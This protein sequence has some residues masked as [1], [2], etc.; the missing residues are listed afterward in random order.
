M[1]TPTVSVTDIEMHVDDFDPTAAAAIYAE[2]GA[3]VVRGLMRAYAHQVRDDIYASMDKA[4][5][6]LDRATKNPNGWS[7]PDGTLWIPAPANFERDKQIMVTSCHYASSAA[8]FRSAL[9]EKTL[10]FAEAVLGPNVE[11]FMGGQCLC[12]EPVGGHPKMLHQDGAYFEHKYEGPLAVLN[13]AVDTPV[14]RGALHVVPGSHKL[15]MLKHVD[16]E[17]H[18]GLDLDEWPWEKALPVEGEA[19]DGIFFHLRTIHGSKP[20]HTDQPRPVF[21]HRYRRADDFVTI[22]GTNVANREEAE[23]HAAEAKKENQHGFMVRGFRPW[24][25]TVD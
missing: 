10:D 8:F 16:T 4:I 22:G 1:T 15:G 5:S 23:K 3:L 14:E 24:T 11:L 12:K 19:G 13:Y 20:N 2:H 17:S 25:E 6:L 9:D 7:T 18:L 21:I